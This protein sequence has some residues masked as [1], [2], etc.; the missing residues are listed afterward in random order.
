MQILNP[1]VSFSRLYDMHNN[2]SFKDKKFG[3]DYF[4]TLKYL[5]KY[6]NV[7]ADLSVII[8]LFMAKI[9]GDLAK[10]QKHIHNKLLFGTDYPVPFSVL[11]SYHSLG[12]KKRLKIEKI[13]N[14]LD[15]Y[16]SFFN[17][18]FDENSQIY[19]NWQKLIK[20]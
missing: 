15:R 3:E 18:Y 9:V 2:F 17:E 10:N 16:I 12:L 7:Y 1:N 11:F 14:P 5:E 20:E 4:K 6:E 13:E 19:S 8:A